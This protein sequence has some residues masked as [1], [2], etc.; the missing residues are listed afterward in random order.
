MYLEIQIR[1]FKMKTKSLISSDRQKPTFEW[2]SQSLAAQIMYQDTVIFSITIFS[3]W[4]SCGSSRNWFCHLL[5]VVNS[6]LDE[7][8]SL[9]D[10]QT[11][12]EIY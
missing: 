12:H 2:S 5:L 9:Q 1:D 3:R 4:A 7:Q 8:I 11:K 10:A 6:Y